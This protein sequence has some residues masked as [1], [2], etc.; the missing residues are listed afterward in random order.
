MRFFFLC[1]AA[2][3][4][5][6]ISQNT[7]WKKLHSR[8]KKKKRKINVCVFKPE[9]CNYKNRRQKNELQPIT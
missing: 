8:F 1:V 5:A 6:D 9:K 7:Y 3:L 2:I 4:A